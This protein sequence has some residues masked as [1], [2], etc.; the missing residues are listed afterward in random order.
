MQY[1]LGNVYSLIAAALK[2]N[3]SHLIRTSTRFRAALRE[4]RS[5]QHS[6]NGDAK[7][8]F[9]TGANPRAIVARVTTAPRNPAPMTTAD[10]AGYKVKERA[11]V[12]T[13]YR[14]H[15]VC[16]M[17][18]PS[19]GATTVL[20]ILGMIEGWDM[21]AM[22]KDN[23]MSWHLLAEAMQLSY[24]DRGAYLGDADFVSVPVNGL[25]D[26]AYV[27]SRAALID[28]A[29]ALNSSAAVRSSAAGSTC[30]SAASSLP[31]GN[32]CT[33]PSTPELP[34]RRTSSTSSPAGPSRSTITVADARGG[35]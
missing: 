27:K 10:I 12:C 13:F 20:G 14:A 35:V 11:P 28:P 16:G 25:L 26:P 1:L 15:K 33:P 24:A 19:S 9:Y 3:H 23:P 8:A 18:P 7:R 22:G 5:A 21:K 2:L 30:R 29:R 6:P 4:I 17:G 34:W 31:P 32:T